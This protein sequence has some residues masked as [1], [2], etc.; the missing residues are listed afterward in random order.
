M[1][2]S[3]TGSSNEH[4]N[5]LWE[6]LEQT[7]AQLNRNNQRADSPSQ[8]IILVE[9]DEIASSSQRPGGDAGDAKGDVEG[10]T[11]SLRE[12]RPRSE[13]NLHRQRPDYTYQEYAITIENATSDRSRKRKRQDTSRP[14]AGSPNL[15]IDVQV[16]SI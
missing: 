9:D 16:R 1:S 4:F 15:Q 12:N 3:V 7:E 5:S 14:H 6:C 8:E 2:G 11:I 13:Q 10:D